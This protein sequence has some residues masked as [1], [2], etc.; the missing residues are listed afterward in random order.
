M[1]AL[2]LSLPSEKSSPSKM[3]EA[4]VKHQLDVWEKEQ[5]ALKKADLSYGR[6][7]DIDLGG[8][9]PNKLP[10]EHPSEFATL[11]KSALENKGV[12]DTKMAFTWDRLP[13]AVRCAGLAQS[14]EDGGRPR[15]KGR[16]DDEERFVKDIDE[17]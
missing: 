6:P 9:A 10:G 13:Y 3:V 7:F 2:L 8:L 17:W 16:A 11:L 5:D 1:R 15:K 14:G 4:A 12:Q